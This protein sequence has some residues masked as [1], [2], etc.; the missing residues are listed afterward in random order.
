MHALSCRNNGRKSPIKL[1]HTTALIGIYTKHI[2]NFSFSFVNLQKSQKLKT[3]FPECS[4]ST[5]HLFFNLIP[6]WTE[7]TAQRWRLW[8]GGSMI[9]PNPN[10]KRVLGTFSLFYQWSKHRRCCLDSLGVDEQVAFIR[11]WC[12]A[13]VFELAWALLFFTPICDW[14]QERCP[15]ADGHGRKLGGL[16]LFRQGRVAAYH[17]S[18]KWH[19]HL[20]SPFLETNTFSQ[21]NC[22]SQLKFLTCILVFQKIK[23][24]GIICTI[25]LATFLFFLTAVWI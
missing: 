5:L 7:S 16:C 12:Q 17:I 6:L 22:P 13:I 1:M 2:H 10:P 8:P 11:D 25:I 19:F 3:S 23:P 4:F 15:S 18:S 14:F 24:Y 9:T 20:L 21:S